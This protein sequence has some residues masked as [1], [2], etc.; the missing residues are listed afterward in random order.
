MGA[1]KI[2]IVEDEMITALD[3]HHELCSL[4]Y[5]VAGLATS[6]EEAVRLTNQSDP[7]LIL[8]D[9]RLTG[10]MD[11]IEAATQ[12]QR[13]KSV[14]VIYLTANAHLL[15]RAFTE[16]E[17]PHICLTKPFSP[18]DLEAVISIALAR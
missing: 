6:G 14:P 11:G 17:E 5:E 8:M 7:D 15:V 18:P 2:L 9:L 16:M 12:I 13:V 4:G 10:K 3:L 1:P